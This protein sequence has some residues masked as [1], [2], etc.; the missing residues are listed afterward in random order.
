MVGGR[1]KRPSVG[2][3]P[4]SWAGM[5]SEAGKPS[6]IELEAPLATLCFRESGNIP[7]LGAAKLQPVL[8]EPRGDL[9]ARVDA[10]C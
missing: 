9:M 10:S 8:A 5:A 2:E 7:V 1:G 4:S 6:A 3:S